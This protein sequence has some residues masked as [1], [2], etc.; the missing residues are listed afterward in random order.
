[1]ATNLRT[2][3]IQ[4]GSIMKY[5]IALLLYLTVYKPMV[6]ASG[7]KGDYDT[8]QI[9]AMWMHCTYGLSQRPDYHPGAA[10]RICDCFMDNLRKR[11]LLKDWKETP[12]PERYRIVIE[13]TNQCFIDLMIV[14][15]EDS[16]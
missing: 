10:V 4:M 14:P 3:E 2:T 8:A 5:V 9:R 12:G 11:V 13:I 15:E 6:H 7:Y 16:I 1:M